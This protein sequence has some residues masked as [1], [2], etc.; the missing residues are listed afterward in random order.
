MQ[1]A[2]SG[3]SVSSASSK[4]RIKNVC[5]VSSVPL[6]SSTT[7]SY[8]GFS[9]SCTSIGTYCV[10]LLLSSSSVTVC[11]IRYSPA[12][13]AITFT[14]AT[15]S[16]SAVSPVGNTQACDNGPLLSGSTQ[17]LVEPVNGAGS[18]Q[19]QPAHAPPE[20]AIGGGFEP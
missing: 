10:V 3:M 20:Q 1:N 6:M 18:I 8:G 7:T 14:S 15:S 12:S 17:S 4:T 2:P 9:S 16:S 5:P 11:S 13:A 19:S